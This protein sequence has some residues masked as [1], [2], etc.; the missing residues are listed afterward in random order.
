V[1]CYVWEGGGRGIVRGG[2]VAV[3]GGSGE[4]AGGSAVVGGLLPGRFHIGLRHGLECL[5]GGADRVCA[6]SSDRWAG[7]VTKGGKMAEHLLRGDGD[8]HGGF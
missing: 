8:A 7:Y 4:E 6:C 5:V 3:S 1:V 2:G